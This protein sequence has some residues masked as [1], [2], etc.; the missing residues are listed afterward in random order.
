M[1]Q[2]N[3]AA[4]RMSSPIQNFG[5]KITFA[6]GS[7]TPPP[8][9]PRLKKKLSP[10][11]S[12]SPV[13]TPSPSSPPDTFSPA[14][15]NMS[16]VSEEPVIYAEIDKDRKWAERRLKEEASHQGKEGRKQDDEEDLSPS[17]PEG[18]QA[19]LVININRN[20]ENKVESVSVDGQSQTFVSESNAS[21]HGAPPS[22]GHSPAS[23]RE[24]S[25]HFESQNTVESIK[26]S[27]NDVVNGEDAVV[28]S[29]LGKYLTKPVVPTNST[30]TYKENLSNICQAMN[31]IVLT[32]L[33][34]INGS[35]G[36]HK[37]EVV[38]SEGPV[39][40]E[41]K[42]PILYEKE[43]INQENDSLVENESFLFSHLRQNEALTETK[44]ATKSENPTSNEVQT[45]YEIQSGEKSTVDIDAIDSTMKSSVTITEVKDSAVVADESVAINNDDE[46]NTN[47]KDNPSAQSED[48]PDADMILHLVGANIQSV[49]SHLSN[50]SGKT[51]AGDSNS[52]HAKDDL[53]G[54]ERSNNTQS[55][56]QCDLQPLEPLSITESTDAMQ[57]KD[58]CLQIFDNFGISSKD[59]LSDLVASSAK[60][61]S[62]KALSYNP[63]PLE[64]PSNPFPR[65]RSWNCSGD[66]SS[67]CDSSS[68]SMNNIRDR[69]FTVAGRPKWVDEGDLSTGALA[70]TENSDVPVPTSSTEDI[71]A[72]G[73]LQRRKRLWIFSS[74][75]KPGSS[76]SGSSNGNHRTTQKGRHKDKTRS[77]LSDSNGK[78]NSTGGTTGRLGRQISDSVVMTTSI[79][80]SPMSPSNPSGE[81]TP[82]STS[83]PKSHHSVQ[84]SPDVVDTPVYRYR[85]SESSVSEAGEGLC[86]PE[87]DNESVSSASSSIGGGA[88]QCGSYNVTLP[89]YEDI[90]VELTEP[91]DRKA[92]F[93]A[94]EIL[95]SEKSFLNVLD[96]LTVDFPNA[97]K[98]VEKAQRQ[99]IIPPHEMDGILAGLPNLKLV[100]EELKVDLEDRI[101]NWREH[102]KLADVIVK[103]GPFLKL[104][105]HYIKNFEKTTKILDTCCQRYP[106]FS[107]ALLDFEVSERCQKLGLKHYM[108]KPVQRMPQYRLLLEDYLKHLQPNS[109][110]YQDTLKALAI[111]K[112]VAE[113]ANEAIRLQVNAEKLM[114]LQNRLAASV[115]MKADRQL[116]KE[117]ELL[118]V[119]RKELKP[120]FFALVYI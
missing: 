84:F 87:G 62:E 65:R 68:S 92:F 101:K 91:K 96:L 98:N 22:V 99:P 39:N 100:N 75:G 58:N 49:V 4:N 76:S 63:L 120:R 8:P 109:E 33:S 13:D 10:V 45:A 60:T 9:P 30:D 97:I 23:V 5:R 88:V 31:S 72:T 116:M 55:T 82:T 104:Y 14:S 66:S 41:S 15:T 57:T 114:H 28:D 12:L 89:E 115:I 103:K 42:H 52:L 7:I 37:V 64:D 67:P 51:A 54:Q 44:D 25:S 53:T 59:T 11:N 79:I 50:L 16:A 107:K 69:A 108:L 43:I 32:D 24:L 94:R 80:S 112:D 71:G 86:L 19:S 111:V 110:D 2:H 26:S 74:F 29:W 27:K 93:V 118:K 17:V 34:K 81:P 40:A 117:G 18:I 78:L 38:D 83:T 106:A 61:D 119:C 48:V 113:H 105:S 77:H 47:H 85:Y 56:I 20:M 73:S 90:L 102:P 6:T 3:N 21:N 1:Q 36:S 95:S 35:S 46:Y 70:D